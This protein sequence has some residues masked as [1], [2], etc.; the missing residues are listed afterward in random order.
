MGSDQTKR[1]GRINYE[2]K[3][4]LSVGLYPVKCVVRGDNS[5]ADGFIAVVPPNTECV[6]F[7][8]DGSFTASMSLMG[9]DP[10]IRPGAVE[11]VKFWKD[12]GFIILYITARPDL[13]KQSVIEWLGQHHFPHGIVAFGDGISSEPLRSKTEYLTRL[14]EEVS[15][16]FYPFCLENVTFH[17]P[18]YAKL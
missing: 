13:Q 2:L 15:F 1:G 18:L 6:V 10:K 3:D 8:I 11:V 16:I 9:R 17:T 4:K 7:S 14:R 12:L 5:T